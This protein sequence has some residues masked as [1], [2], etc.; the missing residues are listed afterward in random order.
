VV[1]PRL[2]CVSRDG[3][4]QGEVANQGEGCGRWRRVPVGTSASYT[5]TEAGDIVTPSRVSILPGWTSRD[6]ELCGIVQVGIDQDAG[7]GGDGLSVGVDVGHLQVDISSGGEGSCAG[8]A[9][10]WG[11]LG[12]GRRFTRM[13]VSSCQVTPPSVTVAFSVSGHDGSV[14][15]VVPATCSG[16]GVRCAGHSGLHV[17]A[18]QVGCGG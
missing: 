7:S 18:Y 12:A 6:R 17:F 13:G 16:R 2:L 1:G 8:Y 14:A 3:C 9:D 15:S 11:P 10:G 5:L 4:S